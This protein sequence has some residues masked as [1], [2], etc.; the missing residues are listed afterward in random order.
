MMVEPSIGSTWTLKQSAAVYAAIGVALCNLVISSFSLSFLR[1][2]A[3][4]S[5]SV[6]AGVSHGICQFGFQRT[7]L[8]KQVCK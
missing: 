7:M 1:L 8:R 6:E 4:I 5:A 2:M 3:A